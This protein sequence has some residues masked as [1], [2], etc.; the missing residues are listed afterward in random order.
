MFTGIIKAKG[1]IREI[2]RRGG[3]ARMAIVADEGSTEQ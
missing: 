2:E 1:T 3:D